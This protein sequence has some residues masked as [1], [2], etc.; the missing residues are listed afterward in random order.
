MKSR[1]VVSVLMLACIVG[2]FFV[3]SWF[4]SRKT[5]R[6]WA[7]QTFNR[8]RQNRDNSADMAMWRQELVNEMQQALASPWRDAQINDDEWGTAYLVMRDCGEETWGHID[9]MSQ[10]QQDEM[11]RYLSFRIQRY[12]DV[13][14]F[15]GRAEFKALLSYPQEAIT[16]NH[17]KVS[18]AVLHAV[19]SDSGQIRTTAFAY[20]VRLT[21]LDW[22][23]ELCWQC[24][25]R[26][27][28]PT[29]VRL[30]W[31]LQFLDEEAKG[32]QGVGNSILDFG[33]PSAKAQ[34]GAVEVLA[35]FMQT[36]W[37]N[38]DDGTLAAIKMW[39]QDHG[40]PES[41]PETQAKEESQ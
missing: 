6:E 25:I 40:L 30:T 17:D 21:D 22:G 34:D 29:G 24:M 15:Q 38:V 33:K 10:G 32:K 23:R 1:I 37:P 31:I 8:F 12:A 7:W 14:S 26:A 36:D 16:R 11:I 5:R 27:S 41:R 4:E 2:G 20:V 39:K 13:R 28:Y 9:G 18:R 19:S 3:G 35:R